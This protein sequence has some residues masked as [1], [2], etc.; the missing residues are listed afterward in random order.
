M[1]AIH[2]LAALLLIVTH[3]HAHTCMYRAQNMQ[4]CP[5]LNGLRTDATTQ[6]LATFDNEAQTVLQPRMQYMLTDLHM[7]DTTS[8]P[9]ITEP[10][11][12]TSSEP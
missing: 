4:V 1:R 11:Q 12:D 2:T 3:T 7:N 10:Q 6:H 9:Q 5:I 8:K